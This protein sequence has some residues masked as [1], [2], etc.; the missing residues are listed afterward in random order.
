ME[1][2]TTN[3]VIPGSLAE[4]VVADYERDKKN[5]K[6]LEARWQRNSEAFRG[7]GDKAWKS[8][9]AEGHRT[10][11]V[12]NITKQKVTSWIALAAK[13]LIG[14]GDVP[15]ELKPAPWDEIVGEE[16]P[17]EQKDIEKDAIHDME[18]LI[19]QQHL[20]CRFD[21][22]FLL[23]LV[24]LGLHG[25]TYQKNVVLTVTRSGWRRANPALEDVGD[26]TGAQPP[27]GFERYEEGHLSP[28]HVY[29]SNWN[30]FRDMEEPF[31]V[32]SHVTHRE[33]KSAY[34]LRN[35]KK[36]TEP[37]SWDA[38]ALKKA[39]EHPVANME[40]ET[41]SM[42][43]AVREILERQ[44]NN[45]I[46]ERWG[47]CPRDRVEA[48]E[49]EHALPPEERQ[50]TLPSEPIG[51][52]TKAGDEVECMVTVVNGEVCR[53]ARTT[54]K[55]RP[56][57][58]V[59]AQVNPDAPGG[60]GTADDV[61][62][63]QK[64][65]NGSLRAM[66]DNANFGANMAGFVQ[67]RYISG[68]FDGLRPGEINHLEPECDDARKAMSFVEPPLFID[69]LLKLGELAEKYADMDSM[70]PKLV[71]GFDVD[72]P[73]MRATV[74]LQQVEK[75]GYFMGLCIRNV[76]EGLIEPAVE[77]DYDWNM[78]D[79]T[80][81]KGKGNYIVRALGFVSYK[82][83]VERI[84]KLERGLA[85]A[86]SS[87]D[88]AA[89]AKI[90][91]FWTEIVKALELEVDEAVKS[92]EEHDADMQA[93]AQVA[94][95]AAQLAAGKEQAET[96]KLQAEASATTERAATERAKT[97]S[98]IAMKHANPQPAS[99]GTPKAGVAPPA[100]AGGRS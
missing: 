63:D 51:E 77:W 29:V 69:A 17:D 78:N 86:L 6:T 52:E 67:D 96:Q 66:V 95:Q 7:I 71:Q 74:A 5:R 2:P 1:S 56:I 12:L 73:Q 24:S 99:P 42:A 81:V 34:W 13:I 91:Y 27:T 72:E 33:F 49:K 25:L 11:A 82:D 83:K 54:R 92:V 76:D 58:E 64:L 44:N 68:K 75:A 38:P 89:W 41:G 40:S 43:P 9:E 47:L 53:F 18:R 93:Q 79:P 87:P 62:S 3:N 10:D 16:L 65:A 97:L 59:V 50:R 85:L 88:V 23:N 30:I 22:H 46:L 4:F 31:D 84:T 8:G 100:P 28:G 98:D 48:Y 61:A 94:Q 15:F 60:W 45:L 37:G 55:D 35:R 26:V 21:R 57:L 90:R 20:D 36:G 70:I 19:K 14:D 32:C 39:I 80:V